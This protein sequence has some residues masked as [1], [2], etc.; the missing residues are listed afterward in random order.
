MTKVGG[1]RQRADELDAVAAAGRSPPRPRAAR[2]RA[3]PPR[4]CPGARRGTRS[5]PAWR[6]RSSRRR[7]K[8]ACSS[9][10]STVERHQHGGVDAAV[11]VERGGLLR[12]R[13]AEARSS[14][15]RAAMRADYSR[16]PPWTLSSSSTS[17]TT[18]AR[19]ARWPCRRAIEVVEPLNWLMR[20]HDYV[21]ATRDWHPRRP[22]LVLRAGR[23]LAG[24]LRAGHAG[25]RAAIEPRPPGHRPDRGQGPGARRRGLLGVRGHR[26]RPGS[27]RARRRGGSHRRAR[28]GLLREGHRAGRAE[29]G[30]PRHR[31]PERDARRWRWRRATASAPWRSCAGPAWWWRR[32]R[33][34]RCQTRR[35]ACARRARRT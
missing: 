26:P 33:A 23:A 15:A 16:A 32:S 14:S 8:T 18:S 34:R 3:G 24:A 19:A 22:R 20:Q 28:A 6:R 2:C 12:A 27:A 29:G 4:R 13:A 25:R 31:P 11:R 9:P 5:R 21:V 30:L 17:R 1:G 35:A 10:P 7:V